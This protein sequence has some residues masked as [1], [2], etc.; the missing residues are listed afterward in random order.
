MDWEVAKERAASRKNHWERWEEEQ[1][2]KERQRRKVEAKRSWKREE[3]R[4]ETRRKNLEKFRHYSERV[5]RAKDAKDV[6]EG[7]QFARLQGDDL[8]RRRQRRPPEMERIGNLNDNARIR[9]A[10]SEAQASL[11]SY[12]IQELR[13]RVADFERV[14]STATPPTNERLRVDAES[15]NQRSEPPA[16]KQEYRRSYRSRRNY[17]RKEARGEVFPSATGDVKPS[18]TN[19]S[20]RWTPETRS[21]SGWTSKAFRMDVQGLLSGF[22]RFFREDEGLA[23]MPFRDA[24]WSDNGRAPSTSY[25]RV[26]KEPAQPRQARGTFVK[27]RR[28]RTP[29]RVE[30]Q[31]RAQAREA[32]WAAIRGEAPPLAAGA[33]LGGKQ[34]DW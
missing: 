19:E 33:I 5:E 11:E 17:P 12:S 25:P 24:S 18:T 14:A 1:K 31:R 23:D 20:N 22:Q 28:T 30:A 13:A 34:I 3:E 21:S 29:P 10:A 4:S 6:G 9:K 7:R 16:R 27:R 32:A 26:S 15:K 2:I 8:P